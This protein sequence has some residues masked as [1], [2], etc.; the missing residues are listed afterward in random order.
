MALAW[1]SALQL[2]G[3]AAL[4]L[5]LRLF[6]GLPDSGWAFA[7]PLGLLLV[8]FVFWHGLTFGLI[9]NGRQSVLAARSGRE[10]RSVFV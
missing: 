8:S 2:C 6:R 3:L 1:W 4:P 5:T 9:S 7:R 10:I